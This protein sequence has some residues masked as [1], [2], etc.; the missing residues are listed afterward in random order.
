MDEKGGRG[1]GTHKGRICHPGKQITNIFP[2]VNKA[3]KHGGVVIQWSKLGKTLLCKPF[4]SKTMLQFSDSVHN[5]SQSCSANAGTGFYDT[6]QPSL[7]QPA[8]LIFFNHVSVQQ[9]LFPS[10]SN[11]C[12]FGV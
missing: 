5:L 7:S 1:M 11:W 6:I 3:E 4:S 8:L 9:L 12:Q 2:Y 10:L